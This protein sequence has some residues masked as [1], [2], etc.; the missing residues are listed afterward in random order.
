MRHQLGSAADPDNPFWN[1]FC[2]ASPFSQKRWD[3][4]AC[5]QTT[6]LQSIPILLLILVGGLSVRKLARR[7]RSGLELEKGGRDA[8]KIKL[9][10]SKWFA[11]FYLRAD[12]FFYFVNNLG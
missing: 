8:L 12:D 9:V 3:F 7:Y 2:S 11:G 1:P 5:F 10:S 4:T 6:V